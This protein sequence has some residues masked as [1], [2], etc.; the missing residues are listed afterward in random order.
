MNLAE[1]MAD[2]SPQARLLKPGS[3]LR[4]EDGNILDARSSVTLI[5]SGSTKIVVDT[6]LP[7][8]EGIIKDRLFDLGLR[9][10]D[11]DLVVNTHDH[12]D[13]CGNN[14]LFTQAEFLSM[15]RD[16]VKEG[17]VIAPGVWI[18]ET[19]GHSLDSLSVVC[20]SSTRIVMAGDAIPI[21]GNYIKWAPPRIH[22]DREKAMKSMSKIVEVA[23]VVV[24]GH[25]CPF[26]V[27]EK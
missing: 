4:D 19:P 23:D 15:G 17:D 9:P 2:K 5:T 14:H 16:L 27:K 21:L 12:P 13:H 11:V 8:E 24:P 6:G 10:Q 22:V 1:T 18:M 20:E 25:G 26:F 3:L 7:G